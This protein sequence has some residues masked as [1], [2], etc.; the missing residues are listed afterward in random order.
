MAIDVVTN[1]VRELIM[2][3]RGGDRA[4]Q[5]ELFG[6]YRD[7]LVLLA[8][9]SLS[10]G[11]RAKLSASDVVQEALLQAHEAIGGF[12]GDTEMEMTG[13]L[14]QILSRRLADAGRRFAYQA[15]RLDRE[16]SLDRLVDDSSD[17]LK[18]LP[19]A[20]GT[21]PSIGA[22]RREAGALVADA[23]ARLKGDDREVIVLRSLE[24]L[25]W[26]EVARRMSR[27]VEA[28]RALW[29]RAMQR[30]GP[31]LEAMRWKGP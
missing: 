2:R 3:A 19:A 4:A 7:Y 15:R 14:R 18:C 27:S 1:S 13:W 5:D 23:L 16:R 29:G 6:R 25:E 12:R 24:E 31:V 20:R 26:A 11:L 30:L 10:R 8:R 9:M 22:E 17:A 21:S 28:V